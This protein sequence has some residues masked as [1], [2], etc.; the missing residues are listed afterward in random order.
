M[1]EFDCSKREIAARNPASSASV[2]QVVKESVSPTGV[3][4]DED[5]PKPHDASVADAAVAPARARIWRRV[6]CMGKPPWRER[7]FGRSYGAHPD[8]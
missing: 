4:D 8:P 3:D 7:G 2:P 1:P 6:S 5:G